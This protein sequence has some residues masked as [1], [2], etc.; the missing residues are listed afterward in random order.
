MAF[1][2]PTTLG[3]VWAKSPERGRTTGE[4]LVE[5][6]YRV[7]EKVAEQYRLRP[8]LGE[9]LDGERFWH[10]AFWS[11]FLHDFGKAASG[12]Q[13]QLLPEA[14]KPWGKRH[15]VLSLAFVGWVFPEDHEDWLWIVSTIVSHH[16]DM[17]DIRKGYPPTIK[18]EY[19]VIP[20]MLD[21]IPDEVVLALREWMTTAPE[22]W[23]S[24][25]GLQEAN[26]ELPD[27]PG[28]ESPLEFRRKGYVRTRTAL[29][30]YFRL[31][32][33]LEV[34]G[35]ED[36][37]T[38]IALAH[39]GVM[40]T[41]DHAG[42]AHA[43]QF[44]QN[45]V[46]DPHELLKRFDLPRAYP[47]QEMCM[48]GK[49]SVMFAAPTGSGKT[50]AALLWAARQGMDGGASRLY[51]ILPFQAS[52]NAMQGRLSERFPE[53]VGLQHGRSRFALYRR[54]LEQEEH[55]PAT[56]LKKA[57]S[58]I[59]LSRLHY[60]PIRV[61]SPYQMLAAMYRLRGYE[62]AL[63]DTFDGL[64]V[65]DE[66]HAYEAKRLAL[67]LRMAEY[68]G[69]N[70]NGR[71]CIMS[72]TF[73]DI[74][75][76]WLHE[77]IPGLRELPVPREVFDDFRRHRI[78]L[79][80]GELESDA[81]LRKIEE[82]A[83]RG[84]VLVCCNTVRRAQSVYERLKGSGSELLLGLLHGRFN[85]RDRVGKE[86]RLLAQMGTKIE[87]KAKRTVL[88]ATQVVEVSLDIDFDTIF[89]EPAPL[90]ALLQ[91]FGR[92]NRGMRYD[93]SDVHVFRE[94]RE[95]PRPYDELLVQRT[96]DILER[97][98]GKP[99]DEK[100]VSSLLNEIYAGEVSERWKAQFEETSRI[101]RRVCIGRLFPY[102]SDMEL[103]QEFYKMFD[104]A[105]VVPAVLE[106]QFLKAREENLLASGEL[107]VTVSWAQLM[108]LVRAKLVRS[109]EDWVKVVD[110][111]YDEE[112]GLRLDSA[113]NA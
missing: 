69:K 103:G 104:G 71:F 67:I 27:L 42:S 108:R 98:N 77:A 4:T 31:E 19:G 72:A 70:Y 49:G 85:I 94:P 80:D 18:P 75:K 39:R 13:K 41:A 1:E 3:S 86:Q 40:V 52:M 84:S 90:D 99:I 101:F 76:G 48:E 92:V 43:E 73:P 79:L 82:A 46:P 2:V 34:Q 88:V 60:F 105:E 61:L 36:R 11:A 68:L 107:P 12:F 97:E 5:H 100:R 17:A 64:F 54:F 29:D 15:E 50:E 112:Y 6:T 56:A 66:I 8:D 106:Q 38:L 57:R 20:E 37:R 53:S 111:P 102:Q 10:R 45:P 81:G 91:R 87:S 16:R 26:I 35:A 93:L 14:K 113:S 109:S 55:S 24:S 21:E 110:V 44:P 96:L 9:R 65:F 58:A 32:R 51:Y 47:H 83:G 89:T 23:I 62:S 7:V 28:P 33:Q 59:Q 63:A 74:L 95:K 30:S 25:L 78:V 22:K